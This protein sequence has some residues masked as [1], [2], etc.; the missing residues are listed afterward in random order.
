MVYVIRML[1]RGTDFSHAL[2]LHVCDGASEFHVSSKKGWVSFNQVK[3]N[4]DDVFAWRK[5]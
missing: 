3:V 5:L 1:I 4:F 2:C